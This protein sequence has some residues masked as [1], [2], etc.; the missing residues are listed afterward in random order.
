MNDGSIMLVPKKHCLKAIFKLATVSESKTIVMLLHF[1]LF[2]ANQ[3]AC[4]L[5]HAIAKV[6]VKFGIKIDTVAL[7]LAQEWRGYHHS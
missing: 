7:N 1:S 2:N 4:M 6:D 5:W 3:I